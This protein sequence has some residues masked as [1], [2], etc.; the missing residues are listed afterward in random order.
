VAIVT[1]QELPDGYTSA[2]KCAT[3]LFNLWQLGSSEKN[4]GVLFMLVTGERAIE[5][6]VGAGLE[7]ILTTEFLG[8]VLDEEMVPELKYYNFHSGA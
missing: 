4:D 7:T 8:R 6:E 1:L 3:D 2:K 5:I